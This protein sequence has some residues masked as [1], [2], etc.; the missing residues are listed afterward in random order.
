MIIESIFFL[1]FNPEYYTLCTLKKIAILKLKCKKFINKIFTYPVSLVFL[2]I[3]S[4]EKCGK[5]LPMDNAQPKFK[6]DKYLQATKLINSNHLE[7]V[8]KANEL[9]SAS[10]IAEEKARALFYF[11]RD[12]ISYVFR[13]DSDEKFYNASGILEKGRGFC[14][15]KSILFCALARA[16]EIPAGIHF[17]DIDDYTLPPNFVALLKTRRLYRHGIISLY[18]NGKWNKYDATLDSKL[19]KRNNLIPVEFS[20]DHDCLMQEKTK[21]G[22]Q[23]IKYVKDYGLSADVSFEEIKSWF[24]QYYGHLLK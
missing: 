15:Q 7:I 19:V 16:C 11:M 2:N 12:Q 4:T 22:E 14:T 20:S 13:A 18:L 8:Q 21:S 10:D 17:Y 3:K 5:R 24:K 6:M 1:T 9:T 23:H